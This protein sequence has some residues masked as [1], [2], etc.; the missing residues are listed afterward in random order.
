[1]FGEISH[2]PAVDFWILNTN[3]YNKMQKDSER[4]RIHSQKSV[5]SKAETGAKED[6][7]HF[8]GP[9]VFPQLYLKIRT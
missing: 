2:P 1:M 5:S 8:E 3:E 6:K 4:G 7:S 9:A